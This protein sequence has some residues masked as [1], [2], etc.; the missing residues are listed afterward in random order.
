[1]VLDAIRMK[2]EVTATLV[3]END[4]PVPADTAKGPERVTRTH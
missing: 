1:M 4:L 2:S 3:M